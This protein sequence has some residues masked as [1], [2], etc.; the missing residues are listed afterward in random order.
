MR[1]LYK[2]MCPNCN[3]DITDERLRKGLLCSKC[4]KKP[5]N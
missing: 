1:L 3:G 4:I 5:V 2:G